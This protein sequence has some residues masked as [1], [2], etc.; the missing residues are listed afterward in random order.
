MGKKGQRG[1]PC[2]EGCTCNRHRMR[3]CA[4]DCTCGKHTK[5][6]GDGTNY[7][8][9]H[10]KV[11]RFRGRAP[12]YACVL[13]DKQANHWAQVH[14]T[15]GTDIYKHYQPMCQGCHFR[16]D[17]ITE[18]AAEGRRRHTWTAEQRAR[19]SAAARKWNAEK[20]PE[21]RS[22]NVRRGWKT[23]RENENG[24]ESNS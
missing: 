7:S 16:Y 1:T 5:N 13:C 17:G 3:K 23:R 6:G 21:E 19:L 10:H 15:D 8:T 22:E 18:K 14:G 24:D 2:A 9:L 4:L 11:R 20:T 12:E